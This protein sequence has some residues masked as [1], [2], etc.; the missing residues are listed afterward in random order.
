MAVEGAVLDGLVEV[1]ERDLGGILQIGNGAGD[2]EDPIVSAGGEVEIEHGAL[3]LLAGRGIEGTML[4]DLAVK[5]AGIDARKSVRVGMEALD[6]V[7]AGGGNALAD[8]GG[9]FARRGG[10]ELLDAEGRCFDMEIDPVEKRAGNAGAVAT[11]LI[12]MATTGMTRIAEVAARTGIHGCDEHKAGRK[13]DLAGAAGNGDLAI[14][15]RLAHDLEGTPFEF[16]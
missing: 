3:E 14:L 7:L 15:E 11:D 10:V 4:F 5:H 6:L 16:G 12:G 2:L 1:R 8:G 13:G 9:G